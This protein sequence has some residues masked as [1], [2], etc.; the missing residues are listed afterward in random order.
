[1]LELDDVGHRVKFLVR[2]RDTKFTPAVDDLFAGAG[3]RVLRSPPQTPRANAFAERWVGTVRR[4]CLDRL[5][6]L[7][8]RHL[9]AVLTEYATHDNVHRPH[10]SLGQSS[11]LL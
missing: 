4:E 2:D 7:N 3:I 1:M 10:Q 11:P 5:L 8:Q 9:L 6:I